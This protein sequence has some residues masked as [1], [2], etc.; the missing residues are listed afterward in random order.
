MDVIC[1]DVEGVQMPSPKL[2]GLA[3]RP[4]DSLA[5]LRIQ[6]YGLPLK[7]LDV[8]MMPSRVRLYVRRFVTIVK[9]I[10]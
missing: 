6:N 10:D 4:L 3:N 8:V 7:G 1:S 5:F 9:V 2:A